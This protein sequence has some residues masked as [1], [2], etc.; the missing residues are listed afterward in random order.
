MRTTMIV[1]DAIY[2]AE[3]ELREMSRLWFE[4]KQRERALK[5]RIGQQTWWKI[6]FSLK[7]RDVNC[8]RLL[9]FGLSPSQ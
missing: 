2:I 8:F 7:G 4:V 6:S 5:K 9:L 3:E 1:R